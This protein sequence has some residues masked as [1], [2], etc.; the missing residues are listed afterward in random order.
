MIHRMEG[1]EDS[2][3]LETSTNELYDVVRIEDKYNRKNAE[4]YK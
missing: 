3:Y 4:D 2:F 1:I